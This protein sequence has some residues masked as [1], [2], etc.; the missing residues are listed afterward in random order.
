MQARAAQVALQAHGV[1][2]SC[3]AHQAKRWLAFYPEGS[4]SVDFTTLKLSRLAPVG[5]GGR[6]PEPS[7]AYDAVAADADMHLALEALRKS[8]PF[9]HAV[10]WLNRYGTSPTGGRTSAFVPSEVRRAWPRHWEAARALHPSS[11]LPWLLDLVAV[12]MADRLGWR[13]GGSPWSTE[14]RAAPDPPPE[15]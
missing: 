4:R 13:T 15:F 14:L 5:S 6:N 3:V 10:G 9:L 7:R 8:A 2:C 11:T 12:A 1:G